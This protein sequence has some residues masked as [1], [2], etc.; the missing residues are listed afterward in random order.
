MGSRAEEFFGEIRDDL[1]GIQ[2][3]LVGDAKVVFDVGAYNGRVTGRYL[4]MFPNATVYAFE[5]SPANVKLFHERLPRLD[6]HERVDFY[7]T[8][9]LDYV[10][11]TCFYLSI[12]DATSSALKTTNYEPLD[13]ITVP[14]T[15]LDAFCE[16]NGIEHID[17]L[18]VDA[19]GTDLR[20][21]QGAKNLLSEQ[22]VGLIY[23]E[24]M[25]HVVHRDGCAMWEI[26]EYLNRFGWR[27]HSF[28]KDKS[29][30]HRI[31]GGNGIFVK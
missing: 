12:F 3:D 5:P 30:R 13:K 18:K 7:E 29:E 8:A 14:V 22:K 27:L 24:L 4:E 11:E 25:I 2:K 31:L 19:E 1:W 23:C 15:C 21:F 17:L 16:Q 26:C 6:G 20:V 10:G 9:V 28:W